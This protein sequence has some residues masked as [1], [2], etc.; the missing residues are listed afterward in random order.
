MAKIDEVY[1]KGLEEIL[2]NGYEYE[3]PN[4]KGVIRREIPSFTLRHNLDEGFPAITTRKVFFKG[5]VEELLFFLSGST[6]IRDLWKTTK[7]HEKITTRFLFITVNC[8][9]FVYMA[10][11]IYYK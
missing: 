7:D 10:C 1:N 6:D 2:R 11:N 9:S 5:A 3:D 4:R 8:I